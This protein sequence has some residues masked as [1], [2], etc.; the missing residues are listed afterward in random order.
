MNGITSLLALAGLPSD[1]VPVRPREGE[2]GHGT[3]REDQEVDA[4]AH[5]NTSLPGP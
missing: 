5:Q 4:Q 2:E 3:H 1:A